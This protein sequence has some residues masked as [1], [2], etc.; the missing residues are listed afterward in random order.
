MTLTRSLIDTWLIARFEVLRAVRTWRALALIVAYLV[1]NLGGCWL[2]I[3]GIGQIEEQLAETLGVATTRWPGTMMEQV[4]QSEQMIDLVKFLMDGTETQARALLE[5]P[6]LAI[7]QLWL[8]LLF[9]P[10][11]AATTSSECVAIDVGN[12]AI[13]YE[14]LRTGRAELVAGR[15]FGQVLLTMAAT[16][17]ALAGTWVM[18]M[19]CMAAQPPLELA[20]GL[21]WLG[22][23]AVAWSLPFIGLGLAA[24]QLTASSAWARVLALVVAAG[25]YIAYGLCQIAEDAP[26]TWLADAAEPLLPQTWSAGFWAVDVGWLGSAAACAGLG[27]GYAALGYLRFTTRDL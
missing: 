27:V 25:S 3:Q 5:L 7:F 14:A 6:M 16:V 9:I 4:R 15:F 21:L 8:G 10:F 18:G 19:T 23:R 1:A 11:M 13:R 24:S 26:W 12:R 20:A 2:F 22:P 17:A